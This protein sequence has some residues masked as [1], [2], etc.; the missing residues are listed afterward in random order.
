MKIRPDLL[1]GRFTDAVTS[2]DS[3]LKIGRQ[4]RNPENI[5]RVEFNLATI[6]MATG[7][8]DVALTLLNDALGNIEQLGDVRGLAFIHGGLADLYFHAHAYKEAREHFQ[9]ALAINR[10]AKLP[11]G[12]VQNLEGLGRVD[13]AEGR[14]AQ[15][16]PLLREAL[17]I[18]DSRPYGQERA[19]SRAALAR[20]SAAAGATRQALIWA[21]QAVRIADS[22]GDPA[23]ELE[24]RAARGIALESARNSEAASGYLS[25]IELLESWRGRLTLG[26]L[27]MGVADSHLEVYE[28]A[29]RSLL[30]RG[31][32][33]DAFHVAERARAR[34][35]LELIG[36]ARYARRT[37]VARGHAPA[38]AA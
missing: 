19:T 5:A 33:E 38:S 8:S 7:E 6:R 12:E 32:I 28:G 27:R 1:A 30:K 14:A 23:T 17:A 15:A 24:A 21:G 26:D 13:L 20:A 18:A 29:I 22:L 9:K 3:A 2:Y 11:Y 37:K 36:R 16:I 25:A 10:V 31:R 34:L 4:L 35:L